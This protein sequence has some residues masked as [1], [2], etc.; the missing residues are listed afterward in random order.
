[1]PPART[2]VADYSAALVRALR[3]AG[4]D[5]AVNPTRPCDRDVYHIGNNPAHAAIYAHA[6]DRPGVV[7]LHDA[8][9][10]HFFL[11]R[12]SEQQ[13]VEEFV[14]N[15]GTWTRGLAQE[16]WRG[17]ARSGQDAIYFGYPMLRRLMER[18]RAVVVHN[19][20]AAS[21]AEA[22]HAARI[23]EIPHLLEPIPEPHGYAVECLRAQW[24]LPPAACVFG[25]FGHLRESKRVHTVLNAFE[26]LAAQHSVRLLVAGDCVSSD[27]ARALDARLRHPH[28]LRKPY[29][30][31][32]E[33]WLH[34]A[35]VDVCI[36]LRYPSAGE[37][38]GIG[39]R[40]M[41]LGKPMIVTAGPE[42]S[43]FPA[44]TV[45]PIDAGL[46]EEEMLLCAMQTLAT[47]PIAARHLG[48]AARTFIT[49]HHSPQ[50]AVQGLLS[51]LV[52]YN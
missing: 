42:V 37:T 1:M 38:S 3:D 33:F 25:I 16:L 39:I 5:V 28:V 27:L 49:T 7:V 40:L 20:A 46:A 35:A 19:P 50:L 11:G 15:Y 34:A 48:Q 2:G 32:S 44:N 8:L 26:R 13:Y 45:I 12:G 43:R 30:S 47:S 9:L 14:Y 18:S 4:V 52:D 6:L 29:L 17:R 51:A 22:H 10:H 21:T 41:G 31:E 24:G 23:V 36:N